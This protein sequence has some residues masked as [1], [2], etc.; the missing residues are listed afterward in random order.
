MAAET[1]IPQ[2]RGRSRLQAR[3]R[4]TSRCVRNA[5]GT[6]QRSR[7]RRRRRRR[8]R[9]G[10][11]RRGCQTAPRLLEPVNS[12]ENSSAVQGA[13]AT[14]CEANETVLPQKL[15]ALRPR[16]QR[17]R[18]VRRV[19]SN[20]AEGMGRGRGAVQKYSAGAAASAARNWPHAHARTQGT[21]AL[22]QAVRCGKPQRNA[23]IAPECPNVHRQG[24]LGPRNSVKQGRRAT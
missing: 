15:S 5:A 12:S 7:K 18:K 2:S 21:C 4:V 8:H 24:H 16:P 10:G 14:F 19:A 3:G 13:Q 1:L 11:T 6:R 20:A 9:D 17:G 22:H 23:R